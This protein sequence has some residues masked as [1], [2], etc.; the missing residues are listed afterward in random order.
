MRNR[1]KGGNAT[2]TSVVPLLSYPLEPGTTS[3]RSSAMATGSNMNAKQQALIDQHGG[4]HTCPYCNRTL[5][6]SFTRRKRNKSIK[7]K[8]RKTFSRGGGD[9]IT[10]PSFSSSTVSPTN[11]TTISSASNSAKLQ[12]GADASGDCF[13]TGTCP[14]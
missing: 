9:N 1:S 8:R 2:R 3:Q 10:V 5:T 11:S 4:G 12:S 14:K 13:A 6:K 7:K